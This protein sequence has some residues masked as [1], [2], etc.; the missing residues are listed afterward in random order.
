MEFSFKESTNKPPANGHFLPINFAPVIARES[1]KIDA[2]DA[3]GKW[4][5]IDTV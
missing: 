5:K 3:M 4:K 2:L 1:T